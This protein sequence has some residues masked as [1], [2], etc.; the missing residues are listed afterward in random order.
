MSSKVLP[1]QRK[2]KTATLY[3]A[4]MAVNKQNGWVLTANCTCMAR[5]GSVCSHVSALLFKDKAVVYHKLNQPVAC[6]SQLRA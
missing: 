1:S 4:W 6:T 5:L 2:G 3:N